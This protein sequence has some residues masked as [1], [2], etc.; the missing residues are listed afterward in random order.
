MSSLREPLRLFLLL[1]LTSG[2]AAA[3]TSG[4]GTTGGGT[5][6]GGS[7]GSGGSGGTRAPSPSV[8][9]IPTGPTRTIP[10]PQEEQRRIIFLTGRVVYDDGT[11][12]GGQISIERVCNG[13]PRR[14]GYTDSS[15]HFSLTLGR[16]QGIMQDASVGGIDMA[17]DPYG[18]P[19]SIARGGLNQGLTERELMGCELR[20][21]TE[22]AWSDIILLAGRHPLDNPDVGTIVLHRMG[23]VEGTRISVTSLQAPRDA[24]KAYEHAE[25]AVKKQKWD[26]AQKDLE[27]AVAAY[28]RYADAWV[29]LGSVYR[30]QKR[31]AD[32]RHAF[33][34]ALAI[35]PK[36]MLPYFNLAVMA[37]A[38]RDWQQVAAL[39]DKA[40]ALDAY[41]YPAAYFYNAVAN[42]ELHKFDLA[43]KSARMARRLDSQ[44]KIPKIELVLSNVLFAKNDFSGA[45]QQLKEFLKRTPRG[46]D[47]DAARAALTETEQRI[48][49]TSPQQ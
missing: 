36:F 4:G 10:Q 17:S 16:D 27:K 49:S 18:R 38:D 20:A 15:G 14:E 19:T 40:L 34:Q 22:G 9:T 21:S 28:P 33:E 24:K 3:Q 39:T 42:Y 31:D 45:A 41:E 47:A 29:L 26:E 12:A 7:T 32:A 30:G 44:H 8:T 37:A 2:L 11:P 43:E 5:T 46:P 35:D 13:R 23:R 25:K 48:A 1:L 6:G